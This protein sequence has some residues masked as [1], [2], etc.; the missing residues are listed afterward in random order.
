[1]FDLFP[2]FLLSPETVSEI[3]P[4]NRGLF[5]VV[6]FDE[7][8]QMYVE[9]AIP[10]IFRSKKVIV[11]GDDKQLKPSSTFSARFI[12][13]IDDENEEINREKLAALEEESLLDLAKINYDKV[14]LTYNY[15][16]QSEE[17]INFSN[18]AFYDGRLQIAPNVSKSSEYGL[19]IERIKVENGRWINNENIERSKEGC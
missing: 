4:L 16:S 8:S 12:E 2:C 9:N 3:M 14:H 19:P 13:D 11:A 7:A 10:S 5:D 18:Y 17:L 6:I 1:M 15:R